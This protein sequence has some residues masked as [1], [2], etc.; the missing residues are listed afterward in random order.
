MSFQLNCILIVN[1]NSWC[2]IVNFPNVGWMQDLKK[3][4]KN[5][6]SYKLM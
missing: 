3:K 5:I 4:Q 2:E 1:E 6:V